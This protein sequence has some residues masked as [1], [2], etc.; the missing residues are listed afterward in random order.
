M[1]ITPI[2]FDDQE[3][4]RS[5]WRVASY[6]LLTIVTA[7]LLHVFVTPLR[8]SLFPDSDKFGFGVNSAISLAAALV[9]GVICLRALEKLPLQTL[10]VSFVGNWHKNLLYGILIGIGTFVVAILPA[11]LSG[12][13]GFNVA[14]TIDGQAIAASFVVLFLAAAFEEVFFRGYLLQTFTRSGLAWL[15]IVLTSGFFAAV[16]MANPNANYISTINTAIAGVWF[17]VAYLKTRDLW[18]AFGIHFA[19]NFFQGP[20]FGVELSGMKTFTNAS[21]LTETDS[22]PAWLT[23]GDYGIE[24]SLA[25]TA[26]LLISIAVIGLMPSVSAASKNA[27]QSETPDNL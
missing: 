24:A 17:A 8:A 26:A 21:I 2:I 13:L 6:I 20:I 18:L 14:P 12:G 25:C 9:A 11:I 19:W 23:G 5:G 27:E 7:G 15:P 1:N 3:R 4:L 22:G 10:G 16:H